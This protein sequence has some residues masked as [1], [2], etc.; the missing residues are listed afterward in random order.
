MADGEVLLKPTVG[1]E[2]SGTTLP[3]G[4]FSNGGTVSVSGGALT[5]D[6]WSRWYEYYL[7]PRAFS[8]SGRHI[9]CSPIPTCRLWRRCDGGAGDAWAIIS[10]GSSCAG[11]L[12]RSWNG[13]GAWQTETSTAIPGS[14]F[15]APHRYRIDWSPSTIEYDVDGTL[16]ATHNLTIST[17]MRPLVAE[18]VASGANVSVDGMHMS[19]YTGASSF[20]SRVFDALGSVTSGNVSWN[21]DTPAGTSFNISI[22]TGDTA[23]PDRFLE[24]FRH[25]L[26]RGRHREWVPLYPVHG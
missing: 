3:S 7:Y 10:T 6:R 23:T 18:S 12:A 13:S 1:A 9:R 17:Q 22:R 11:L 4:W 2:F 24:R 8:R 19:P 14:Y 16:V 5:V 20:T 15:G 21:V 26:Q 25:G